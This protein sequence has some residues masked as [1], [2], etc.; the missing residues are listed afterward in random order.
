[1]RA[2]AWRIDEAVIRGEID[3]TVEGRT[4]GK[5][6]LVGRE[7]P[8]VLDLDGDCL[9]DLAGTRLA[10]VNPAPQEQEDALTLVS[11]QIGL[12][13]D[14]TASR[15]CRVPDLMTPQS[16]GEEESHEWR[17]VLF[18]EW[19]SNTN[20]RVVI[21]SDAFQL[22]ISA[23]EWNMDEDAEA[24]Q[25]LSNL[26]AMREF[27]GQ[28]I[29]RRESEEANEVTSEMNEFEW[30]ERLKESDRLTDAYQEVLEKYMEDPDGERKEAFV[31]GW[32]GLL[33]AMADQ[34]EEDARG[35]F[36][37]SDFSDM[38]EEEDDQDEDGWMET[39]DMEDD[40]SHPLQARAQE[41][42]LRAMD[43]MDRESKPDSPAHAVV[44]NLLQVTGKLA[45]ALNGRSSGYEPETGY[46]LA[47][48]KR[49]LSW[50]NE[51]VG[52]CQ[53]LIAV[54]TDVDHR[55]ALVHL[56]S[57]IFEIRD[58]VTELRRELK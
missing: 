23:H 5:V 7:E 16:E 29:Q 28:V 42:A 44:S 25:E 20:G 8:L 58:G 17:N 54:E 6:W 52:A 33:D 13:G 40:D 50:L 9:R 19:F 38:D 49:C 48:L 14:M 45:G 37:S 15:R 36:E 2:M 47:V 3:N 35:G 39:D 11:P 41:I 18:L 10:F 1:M 12:I 26:H 55:A 22:E 51:A 24:A 30:E 57:S 53:E 34:D 27:I 21:E 46:V 31:M 43:L 4:T 56:R 32:D